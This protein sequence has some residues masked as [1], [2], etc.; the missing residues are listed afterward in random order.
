M[1][2]AK[3]LAKMVK[4]RVKDFSEEALIKLYCELIQCGKEYDEQ[5]ENCEMPTMLHDRNEACIKM[6]E[7]ELLEEWS[8]FKR[9]VKLIKNRYRDTEILMQRYS[10]L[11]NREIRWDEACETCELPKLAHTVDAIC[12]KDPN[13]ELDAHW[14][15]FRRTME[16]IKE[17]YKENMGSMKMENNS[18]QRIEEQEQRDQKRKCDLCE[19]QYASREELKEHED[20]DHE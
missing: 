20:D 4:I 15:A 11:E 12:R 14:N 16:S 19:N 17:G 18:T 7:R 13:L 8:Q 2:R 6:S 1:N 9:K 3:N 5:C 10:D